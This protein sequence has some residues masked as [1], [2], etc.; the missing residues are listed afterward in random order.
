MISPDARI[1]RAPSSVKL[2]N[3]GE[4][5]KADSKLSVMFNDSL[6]LAKTPAGRDSGHCRT[7]GRVFRYA[8]P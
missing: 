3:S 7:S 8:R 6:G 2:E 4:A 5:N 1:E